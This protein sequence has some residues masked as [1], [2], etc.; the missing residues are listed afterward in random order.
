MP[1]G[2][3]S[4]QWYQMAWSF[5]LVNGRLCVRARTHTREALS[6]CV[7]CLFSSFP[8]TVSTQS[9]HLWDYQSPF[10]FQREPSWLGG[11]L[12]WE[13]SGL[14][15]KQFPLRLPCPRSIVTETVFFKGKPTQIFLCVW[16][17]RSQCS[18]PEEFLHAV[19]RKP[20]DMI[21]Y[22]LMFEWF[23]RIFLW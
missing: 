16:I 9:R 12:R 15:S 21:I 11:G 3:V 4:L 17:C 6:V 2:Q 10:V 5:V 18:H 22:S 20:R 8:S 23:F 7:F 13:P 14:Y 1:S 19:L